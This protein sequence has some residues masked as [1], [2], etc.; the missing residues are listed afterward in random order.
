MMKS[1]ITPQQQSWLDKAHRVL[2]IEIAAIKAHH[3][4]LGS[5]FIQAVETILAVTYTPLRAHETKANL[6]C[7]TLHKTKTQKETQKDKL[8]NKQNQN[9]QNNT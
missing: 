4:V 5:E 8:E 1:K 3:D 9:K 6:L 2:D 7:H